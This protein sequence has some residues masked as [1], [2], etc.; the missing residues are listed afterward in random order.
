M[1]AA[2]GRGNVSEVNHDDGS[3]RRMSMKQIAI[4]F[5]AGI[6]LTARAAPPDDFAGQWQD[7]DK[8]LATL[9]QE[10]Y[11]IVAVTSGG[12]A[13]KAASSRTEYFLQRDRSAYR[14]S[15]TEAMG[16][17]AAAGKWTVRCLELV[18][19]ASGAQ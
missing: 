12:A 2:S 18:Q 11:R 16:P 17:G 3:K 5:L 9:V 13:G 14:C 7:T 1:G 4:I 8:T 10:G 19:P 15:E 6:A